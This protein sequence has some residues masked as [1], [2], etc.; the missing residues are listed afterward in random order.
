MWRSGQRHRGRRCLILS[1]MKMLRLLVVRSLA[2]LCMATRM[3]RMLA[4]S[5]PTSLELGG[6]HF[7]SVEPVVVFELNSLRCGAVHVKRT[8]ACRLVRPL[9]AR[10]TSARGILPRTCEQCPRQAPWRRRFTIWTDRALVIVV[11]AQGRGQLWVRIFDECPTGK[12]P[13][14][15]QYPQDV[16]YPW[17]PGLFFRGRGQ[18]RIRNPSLASSFQ[19]VV[20]RLLTINEADC[21]C[22]RQGRRKQLIAASLVKDELRICIAEVWL[23][24]QCGQRSKRRT[25]TAD[26]CCHR[27]PRS[28]YRVAAGQHQSDP[29]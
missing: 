23:I 28:T 7:F 5:K 12:R 8:R 18:Q 3:R 19:S 1:L 24:N 17:E 2:P 13:C 15:V 22:H 16:G 29:G 27:W 10:S 4:S 6:I 14:G 26:R 21:D 25:H 20:G 11:S 9:R